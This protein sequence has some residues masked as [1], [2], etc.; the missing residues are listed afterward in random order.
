MAGK[1]FRDWFTAKPSPETL[2]AA[3]IRYA[4]CDHDLKMRIGFAFIRFCHAANPDYDLHRQFYAQMG[5]WA[6]QIGREA[7]RDKVRELEA[8]VSRGV[9]DDD[10]EG[11]ASSLFLTGLSLLA[12]A[13]GSSKAAEGFTIVSRQLN[14]VIQYPLAEIVL[15]SEPGLLGLT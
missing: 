10:P 6:G 14:D 12:A 2:H 8:H 5:A 3:L 7:L 9:D 13:D 4:A 15:L 1:G 11:L